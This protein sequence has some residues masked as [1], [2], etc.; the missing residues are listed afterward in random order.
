[1]FVTAFDKAHEA[2]WKLRSKFEI[3]AKREIREFKKD[4][5]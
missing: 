4:Q 2:L 5:A 3:P 1:M